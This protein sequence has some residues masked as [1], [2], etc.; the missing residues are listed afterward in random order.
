MIADPAS[1]HAVTDGPSGIAA[2]SH[3]SLTIIEMST[4]GPAAIAWLASAIP[5]R[6][7]LLDAP[8]LG[9]IGAAADGSLIIFA[10][11][12]APLLDPAMPLLSTLGSVIHAGPSGAGAAAKL[13]ANSAVFSTLG[14]LGEAVALGRGLGLSANALG[15]VLAVTPLAGQAARR[16]ESI[17]TADYPRRF[18]LTL[19]RKDAD[20]IRQAALS[21]GTELRL[22]DAA[23]TWLADAEAAGW[24]DR[25][26]TAMLA[27]ILG[28]GDRGAGGHPA[29][30]TA[31]PPRGR[32]RTKARCGLARLWPAERRRFA[33]EAASRLAGRETIV[34]EGVR[35]SA[36]ASRRKPHGRFLGSR[37]HGIQY[38][39]YDS[40][41]A[42]PF[43]GNVAGVVISEAA[44][45]PSVMQDIASELAAPTTGFAQ[46]HSGQP[47]A[48]SGQP[49][50]IRFFTP[51]REIDACGHV[52][53][54][55]AAALV[56]RRMW[57][58]GQRMW[59]AGHDQVQAITQAGR[60]PIL[61]R[62][63]ANSTMVGLIYHP[64]PIGPASAARE[65]IEAALS[66]PTD[67]GLPIEVMWSGLRHLVVP[68][69]NL[70]ALAGL[71]PSETALTQL[72]M[73]CGAD[74][75]CVFTSVG[76]HR[77]R[78]RDFCA[79]IGSLEEPAS[80]TTSAA[81][82]LYLTRHTPTSVPA[83]TTVEQ[84]VEM[85][86]PSQIEVSV[87]QRGEQ[88]VATVWGSALKIASGTIFPT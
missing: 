16:R 35:S 31:G 67:P 4:V 66:S 83:S 23:R 2:G 82:A 88:A 5:A 39:L 61:L 6:T 68:V 11:G 24:G 63:A 71:T 59:R 12:P 10:G 46:P 8:V 53:L 44:I 60:L 29:D 3:D 33:D 7:G 81:L 1:L 49:V 50:T 32:G 43:G 41:A 47:V 54:A 27:A 48:S 13:V 18:A 25:D 42:R 64:R 77:V 85:G 37:H 51:K 62:P 70:A 73:S 20:L 17:E 57:R 69:G 9:S 79:P 26:Y 52:T 74:T 72:A 28:P 55:V 15:E 22:A 19:A 76:D 75:I 58:V 34:T 30:L 38:D 84:G 80:G 14:A 45:P 40:F 56:E 21:T 78:M 36:P 86:R 65:D 87:E